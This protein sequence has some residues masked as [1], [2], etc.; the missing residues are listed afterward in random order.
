MALNQ[1]YFLTTASL[2]MQL[3]MG[4]LC[5]CRLSNVVQGVLP[6]SF[7]Q[8]SS[9]ANCS[10]AHTTFC[11]HST[12]LARTVLLVSTTLSG[13]VRRNPTVWSRCFWTKSRKLLV[14]S[15]WLK[16]SGEWSEAAFW[17]LQNVL[18]GQRRSTWALDF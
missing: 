12:H 5:C 11:C 14:C 15:I 3:L 9:L 18:A 17:T 6:F 1:I 4:P 7:S 16:M 10:F 8:T 13:N 2:F